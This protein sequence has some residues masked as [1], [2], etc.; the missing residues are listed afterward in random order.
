MESYFY[1]RKGAK[2]EVPVE[3]IEWVTGSKIVLSFKNILCW[4][5]WKEASGAKKSWYD[6][7]FHIKEDTYRCECSFWKV[8]KFFRKCIVLINYARDP[9]AAIPHTNLVTSVKTVFPATNI[10]VLRWSRASVCFA[11]SFAFTKIKTRHSFSFLRAMTVLKTANAAK[12]QISTFTQ[13]SP[14]DCIEKL[15]TIK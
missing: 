3:A 11:V 1:K 7:E 6:W 2:Y 4:Y 15:L 9:F 13:Y 5:Q 10:L 12:V 14:K 8:N